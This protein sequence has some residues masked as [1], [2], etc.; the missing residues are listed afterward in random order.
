MT[1]TYKISLPLYTCPVMAG[2]PSPADDYVELELNL[3]E[4]LI[5][6]PAATFCV[7]VK[8]NS[9]EG[10]NIKAGDILLVDRSKPAVSGSVVVAVL[11]GEFTVKRLAWTEKGTYLIPE[12]PGYEPI[13]I[14]EDSEFQIWG[15]V[16]YTIHKQ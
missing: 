5:Q 10:A 14:P 7:R 12:H 2:F 15:V 13:Y 9:M 16:T 11:E 1:D 3:N 4:Y 8:G 6:N